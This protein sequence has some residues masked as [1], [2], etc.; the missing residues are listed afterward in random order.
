[1]VYENCRHLIQCQQDYSSIC[2]LLLNGDSLAGVTSSFFSTLTPHD[3]YAEGTVNSVRSNFS[4]SS[5]LSA[6]DIDC[7]PPSGS[8]GEIKYLVSNFSPT[9]LILKSLDFRPF[10]SKSFSCK[11]CKTSKEA[12]QTTTASSK[13]T[14]SHLVPTFSW[15]GASR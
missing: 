1:M 14:V 3:S 13:P 15:I 9:R 2:V 4:S 5:S 12:S 11:S 7:G 6:A 8:A 10:Q